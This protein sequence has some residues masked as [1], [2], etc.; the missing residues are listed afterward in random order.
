MGTAER[1]FEI[2]KYLCQ[3]RYAKM[4]D[5]AEMFGVSVRTIH[6]DIDEIDVSFHVPLVIKRGKYDGGVY[7][8]D[9][10]SFDRI[11]MSDEMTALLIK[12]K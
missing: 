4:T 7:V 8:M 1:K 10:Y 5:L 9:G 6:R 12:V 3:W 11:Y 2:L